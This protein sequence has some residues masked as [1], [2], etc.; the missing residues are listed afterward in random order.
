MK[1]RRREICAGNRRRSVGTEMGD[2]TLVGSAAAHGSE[3]AAG[4]TLEAC[5]GMDAVRRSCVGKHDGDL[6]RRGSLFFPFLPFSS[7]FFYLKIY[8][9][10]KGGSIVRA[11][12]G[13]LELCPPHPLIHPCR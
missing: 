3:V 4:E 13:G 5:R 2:K 9:G 6:L 8:G 11:A 7:F 1:K 12:V 10:A